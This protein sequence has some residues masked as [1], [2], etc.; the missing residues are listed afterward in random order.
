MGP[1]IGPPRTAG[2]VVFCTCSATINSTQCYFCLQGLQS[3]RP[4]I[5]RFL[6]P[7]S[8]KRDFGGR[9]SGGGLRGSGFFFRVVE[10][11]PCLFL[12]FVG[13]RLK[14]AFVW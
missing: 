3:S 5:Q 6:G 2:G 9:D 12:V 10:A 8:L 14:N 13:G 7:C 1:V 4:T 11:Q